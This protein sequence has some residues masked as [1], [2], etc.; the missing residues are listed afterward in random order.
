MFSLQHKTYNPSL[1]Q[2]AKSTSKTK[3]TFLFRDKSV[4]HRHSFINTKLESSGPRTYSKDVIRV[5]IWVNPNVNIKKPI[6][7]SKFFQ[8]NG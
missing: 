2:S 3:Q 4:T 7:I 5:V 8:L 6:N 1:R